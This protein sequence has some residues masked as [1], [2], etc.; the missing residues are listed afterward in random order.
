[1]APPTDLRV[2]GS[3]GFALIDKF[4]GSSTR[5]RPNKK[6]VFPSRQGRW[7]VQVPNDE[8]EEP[9]INSREA[10]SRYD[11][12]QIAAEGFALIDTFYGPGR[13]SSGS[14]ALYLHGRRERC[15]VVYQMPK[16][17]MNESSVG[18]YSK[19]KMIPNRWG[20]S[21]I[22]KKLEDFKTRSSVVVLKVYVVR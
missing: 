14:D 11:L 22:Y 20:Y 10:A 7:V 17:V 21:C 2:I 8:L 1:M 16:D 13:R 15:C 5:R 18:S 6:G 12:R 3:E 19:P 4:Y 9:V